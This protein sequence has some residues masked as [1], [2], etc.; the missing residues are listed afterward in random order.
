LNIETLRMRHFQ[1]IFFRFL[2]G[3]I[4]IVSSCHKE[5]FYTSGD[6]TLM[7][8]ADTI[9]FDTVFTTIGTATQRLMVYNP[10]DKILKISGV[11]LA[12][13]NHSSFLLN[14][15]GKQTTA[16]NDVEIYPKDSLYVFIQVFVNPT[17]SNSPLFI[18]DSIVFHVNGKIQNVKLTAYGQ[19]V[20]L[21]KEQTLKTTVWNADKPYLIYGELTVDTLETLSIAKG[22]T[23]YFHKQGDL[24]V[25]GTLVAMGDLENPITFRGDRLEKDY[26]DIPGQWGG[27]SF[28]SG[29]KGN[30]LAACVIENGTAGVLIENYNTT[31]Q[32]DL[33]LTNTIIR[34]MAYNSLLVVNAHVKAVNCVIAN[35]SAYT[36]GLIGN[37]DYKFY[38]CTIANYYGA[39]AS[40]S[41]SSPT[42]RIVNTYDD[43]N[44]TSVKVTG[45]LNAG[46]YNT[47][48]Y[49]ND[50]EELEIN[51]SPQLTYLFNFC[52]LKSQNFKNRSE[53]SFQDIIWNN[54]PKFKLASGLNL[55]LDT[56]SPAKDKGDHAIGQLYP[57]DIK[58]INRTNDIGPDLGAYERVEKIVK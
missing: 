46:F 30:R 58:N 33:E 57:L 11:E 23:V 31:L 37:G 29:S 19:D 14:I 24:I 50:M 45:A 56:L 35:A 40:R 8:S 18:K 42:L 39:Y 53:S 49:G 20:H 47:I 13:N 12:G 27:I 15:N 17:G 54:D 22:A 25:K 55:E 1:N 10:Y 28:S 7:F 16:L 9:S 26:Q 6:A 43:P 34:N 41:F 3:S 52:L 2:L 4:I 44:Q 38:H 51:D 21:L 48:V 32:P 5:T 36:C